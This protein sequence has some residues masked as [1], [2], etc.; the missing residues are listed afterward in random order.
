MLEGD[1]AASVR[2]IALQ[3][4]PLDVMRAAVHVS[5]SVL[6]TDL[7]FA[8]LPDG[9]VGA[10][11]VSLSTGAR[12]PRF[13]QISIRTGV[14]LGGRVLASLRPM[15]VDD[16]AADPRITSDFVEIVS[17]G[18]G[19]HGIACVPLTGDDARAVGL[20]YVARRAVG[21]LGDRAVAALTDVATFA[22]IGLR[23]AAEHARELELQRLRDRQ[24]L[25]AELHDS[26]AQ[27]LFGI[28]IVARRSLQNAGD[29]AEVLSALQEI[30]DVAAT[31]RND[32]RATLRGLGDGDEGL[33]F[34]A[35]LEGELRLFERT[36]GCPARVVRHGN[37]QALPQ[38]VEDLALDVVLEGLRNAVKH[39]CARL[40]VVF[41]DFSGRELC[42][43]VQSELAGPSASA[44]HHGSTGC[45]LGLL[46]KR[47]R[48]LRGELELDTSSHENPVLRLRVP[49]LVPE[50]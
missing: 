24:R 16:Y 27:A 6:E 35:R 8:A 25:A 34:D 50:A 12:D 49:L 1:A 39:Q 19:L 10:M 23:S 47:A 33:A 46:E 45:G 32:L 13:H 2:A 5:R 18:E 15:R 9:T 42:I 26:V 41:V 11:R 48:Q 3:R 22:E 14:G 17:G 40:A 37:E 30:D 20:L 43:T 36:S 44:A 29:P 28:G 21:G 38:P 31:A 7:A 4:G